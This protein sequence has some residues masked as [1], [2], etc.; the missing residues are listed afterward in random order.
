MTEGGGKTE[1]ALNHF[2]SSCLKT[3]FKLLSVQQL[4]LNLLDVGTKVSLSKYTGFI[5]VSPRVGQQFGLCSEAFQNKY[6]V[7][8]V[9]I[10]V[11]IR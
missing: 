4:S 3:S 5:S 9:Y 8:M 2:C 1:Q 11:M 7:L 10:N 6:Y